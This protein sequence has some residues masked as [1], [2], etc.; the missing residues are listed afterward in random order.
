[1]EKHKGSCFCLS[2]RLFIESILLYVHID[3]PPVHTNFHSC[4]LC[5]VRSH[6]KTNKIAR[7]KE[8]VLT[9]SV[10]EDIERC[11]LVLLFHI[12]LFFISFMVC[13]C[14]HLVYYMYMLHAFVHDTLSS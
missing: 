13:I 7:E 12:A 3:S 5:F 6:I 2:C 1:M 8:G 4:S 10:R 14:V 11:M 9:A